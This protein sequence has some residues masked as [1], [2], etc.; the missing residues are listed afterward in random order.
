M[1]N[2]I[3]IINQNVLS[4]MVNTVTM[5]EE[6]YREMDKMIDSED[7]NNCV[8]AMEMMANCDY[9]K[10]AIYLLFLLKNHFYKFRENKVW[11]HVN[12]TALKEFFGLKNRSISDLEDIMAILKEKGLLTSE[13]IPDILSLKQQEVQNERYRDDEWSG[14]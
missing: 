12:F 8:L 3:P 5:N 6:I 4:S 9:E 2:S 7:S 10:S 11:S 14:G 13:S 1:D